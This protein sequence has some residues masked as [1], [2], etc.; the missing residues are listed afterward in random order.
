M[1]FQKANAQI[2]ILFDASKAETAGNADW[3]IDSD[4]FNLGFSTG[5]AIVG[6]GNESNPQRYPTPLQSTVTS[7]TVESYWKGGIS[8]WGI[9]CVK[10][11]YQVETLPYDGIISYGNSS[12][13]QDLSNYK[14]FVVDEPNIVF[15]AS[16]KTAIVNF[17]KFGGS[18][19]M[20]SD[21]TVSDR[22]NDGWDSPVIWNDLFSTNSVQ[23]NPFGIT[24]DLANFSGSSTNMTSNVN[25][26]LVHGPYGNATQVLW[27]SGTSITINTADN[28][29]VK[30]SVYKTG[31]SNTGNTNVLVAY[32]YFGLGK[33]VAV[34]DSSPFDDGT[35]DP[36]DQLY[37]GY[38]TDASG[39]HQKLIMNA[40]V[41]LATTNSLPVELINFNANQINNYI[42]LQWQTATEINTKQFNIQYS[43]NGTEFN[44]IGNL[45]A[46]GS[47]SIYHFQIP[48]SNLKKYLNYFRLEIIDK[49]GTTTYNKTVSINTKEEMEI[50]L[51]PNPTN[52]IIHLNHSSANQIRI[53]DIAGKIIEEKKINNN[54]INLN[55][56]PKGIYTLYLYNT[57]QFIQS[58]KIIIQ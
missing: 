50:N 8:A 26:S 6:G 44:A 19:F 9:D 41:W 45:F 16:E 13:P 15:T 52:G 11:G 39:N 36:N 22:N 37:D 31:A 42:E 48:L 38:I 12:N 55:H 43:E 24:F 53:V 20:I 58:K 5:P 46:K 2:K 49:D 32:A 33:V 35:G 47:G 21:H 18:L 29:S 56:L 25:D 4:L 28:T 57:N 51:Y 1:L 17:V 14:I 23:Q 34:G 30:A 54:N 10:K 7:T 27:S 40:T 3:V